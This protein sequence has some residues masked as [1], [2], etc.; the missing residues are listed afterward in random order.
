VILNTW[1]KAEVK[2]CA[3]QVTTTT[4]H[5]DQIARW[6][7]LRLIELCPTPKPDPLPDI[8]RFINGLLGNPNDQSAV[9]TLGEFAQ[10]LSAVHF[11]PMSPAHT[12]DEPLP[13]GA[14]ARLSVAKRTST[15][16]DAHLSASMPSPSE[17]CPID[18]TYSFM[19]VAQQFNNLRTN[20]YA[21]RVPKPRLFAL[22]PPHQQL[23]SSKGVTEVL[24]YAIGIITAPDFSR[25]KNRLDSMIGVVTEVSQDQHLN[26]TYTPLAEGT[27][28]SRIAS[29]MISLTEPASG[30]PKPIP[31]TTHTASVRA[32]FSPAT[33]GALQDTL[34]S[35]LK[36]ALG[37]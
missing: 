34:D 31:L 33:F 9:H 36:S 35:V 7:M 13:E 22:A 26:V 37:T 17:L 28:G 3:G 25:A 11:L 30:D 20:I 32:R 21:L 27:D 8:S 12:N 10:L 5:A 29:L 19:V 6:L 18:S 24:N 23:Q 16:D 4:F 1:Q 2:R 14:I 15:S